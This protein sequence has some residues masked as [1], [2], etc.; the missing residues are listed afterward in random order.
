MPGATLVNK[1]LPGKKPSP[2]ISPASVQVIVWTEDYSPP[3]DEAAAAGVG[4]K[5]V[6]IMGQNKDSPLLVIGVSTN[7]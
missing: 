1:T 2:D 3:Y 7:H 4:A 6:Q 5:S